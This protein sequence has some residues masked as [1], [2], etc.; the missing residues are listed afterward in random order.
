MRGGPPRAS[1]PAATRPAVPSAPRSRRSASAHRRS[2]SAS[3][4][5]RVHEHDAALARP[6]GSGASAQHARE[7]R[8]APRRG[9][10]ARER[11]RRAEQAAVDG[12]HAAGPTATRTMPSRST[13]AGMRFAAVPRSPER[14]VTLRSS[15]GGSLSSG[16][17]KRPQRRRAI[18]ERDAA[19]QHRGRDRQNERADDRRHPP[20]VVGVQPVES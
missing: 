3:V 18:A 20:E 17:R 2:W 13:A 12:V 1:C 7:Q 9:C 5:A 16:M 19:G 14:S 6:R 8:G 10:A 4:D 15:G 11:A